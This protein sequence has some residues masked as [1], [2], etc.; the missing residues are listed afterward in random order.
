MPDQSL[1]FTL[2]VQLTKK[3]YRDPYD[4][5]LPENN[6]QAG[7]I[8]LITGGGSGIGAAISKGTKVLGVKA[9][10]TV[11]EDVEN[12]YSKIKATFGRTADVVLANAGWVSGFFKAGED[13][14]DNWWKV[15]EIN[16]KG[17]FTTIH[18]FIK[19]QSN[20]ENPTG[21]IISVGSAASGKVFPSISS[22]AT[23]KYAAQRVL[24]FVDAEYSQL[25]TFTLLPGIVATDLIHDFYRPYAK[26]HPELTGMV[27]LWL[28]Q[29]KAD[30]LT[31]QLVSVNWDLQ[32]M[33]THAKAILEK[34]LLRTQWVPIL[35]VN[36]G[37]GLQ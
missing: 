24:E 4:Y 31:G 6:P 13:P 34:G 25:R 22:Y 9:D 5:I 26:D 36:G 21:T 35:P 17:L 19:S 2:P 27:S 8:I 28:A 33:E 29:P 37:G 14:V 11:A 18:Y 30:F 16:V 7:K 10:I 32:E 1:D 15:Y 23:S 20:P 3:I 12:L